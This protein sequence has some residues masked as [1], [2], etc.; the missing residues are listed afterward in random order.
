[1]PWE[2]LRKMVYGRYLLLK[3]GKNPELDEE[4]KRL[5]KKEYSL[6]IDYG[7]APK[8]QEEAEKRHSSAAST[9]KSRLD[10]AELEKFINN[11]EPSVIQ[12]ETMLLQNKDPKKAYNILNNIRCP[13]LPGFVDQVKLYLQTLDKIETQKKWI[14]LHTFETL[15]EL[16]Q[17]EKKKYKF[18]IF[19]ISN[20][21]D[22]Y[23]KAF[24]DLSVKDGSD[25]SSLALCEA[26]HH[27]RLQFLKEHNCST[28]NEYEQLLI[29]L[30]EQGRYDEKLFKSYLEARC[31]FGERKKVKR[32]YGKKAIETYFLDMRDICKK[33]FRH[34]FPK[35]SPKDF[36]VYYD[37]KVLLS[38]YEEQCLLSGQTLKPE[39]LSPSAISE[40][41][42]KTICQVMDTNKMFYRA[43]DAVKVD[44]EMKNISSVEVRLFEINTLT[45]YQKNTNQIDPT[46]DLDGLQPLLSFTKTYKLPSIQRHVESFDF[47]MIDHR[48]V[49]VIDFLAGMLNSRFLVKM[50]SLHALVRPSIAGYALTILDESGNQVVEKVKVMKGARVYLPTSHPATNDQEEQEE[51]QEIVIPF[52]N[53]GEGGLASVL[54]V[55]EVQP[56]WY[57]AIPQVIEIMEEHY[58]IHLAGDVDNESIVKGNEECQVILRPIASLNDR[59]FPISLLKD[60]TITIA[61]TASQDVRT[62]KTLRPTLKDGKEIVYSFRV[63]D[64]MVKLEATMT[65]SVPL[66][67]GKLKSLST[68]LVLY[69]HSE[70]TP[71]ENVKSVDIMTTL[72][73]RTNSL[74]TQ[75]YIA[76]L[77]GLSGEPIPDHSCEVIV[78]SLL[79]NEMHVQALVTDA[80]GQIHL[81]SLQDIVSLKVNGK[82]FC[83]YPDTFDIRE[84]WECSE[85][86]EI[87]AVFPLLSHSRWNIHL[88]CMSTVDAYP[89]RPLTNHLHRED[90]YLFVKGLPAG[91]YALRMCEPNVKEH[92]I[93]IYVHRSVIPMRVFNEF[94][95]YYNW[96]RYLQDLPLSLTTQITNDRKLLIQLRGGTDSRRVHLLVKHLFE[97]KMLGHSLQNGDLPSSDIHEIFKFASS[98][99]ANDRSL[100]DEY[101]YILNRKS[102]K[103]DLPGNMLP[104]PGPLLNPV[105]FADTVN[106]VQTA[107]EGR[108]FSD[109]RDGGERYMRCLPCRCCPHRMP[110]ITSLDCPPCQFPAC[111]AIIRPSELLVDIPLNKNGVGMID[112]SGASADGVEV[113]V[114]AVDNEKTVQRHVYVPEISPEKSVEKGASTLLCSQVLKNSLDCER[115]YIEEKIISLATEEQPLKLATKS[116]METIHSIADVYLLLKTL[117]ANQDLTNFSFLLSWDKLTEREKNEYY[118]RYNCSELNVFIYFRDRAF[119]DQVIL[120]YLRCK[121]E[122]SFLDL[123]LTG[124]DVTA[125]RKP[126][127]L[128][129]LNAFERALLCSQLSTEEAALLAQGVSG[130]EG[131]CM[132]VREFTRI[133][134]TVLKMKSMEDPVVAEA[135]EEEE[136]EEEEDSEEDSDLTM[137]EGEGEEI[138]RNMSI[139]ERERRLEEERRRNQERE[140]V[141]YSR[142]SVDTICHSISSLKAHMPILPPISPSM[143]G[144]QPRSSRFEYVFA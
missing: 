102:Q 81:G 57:F 43:G 93:R 113:V 103:R 117:T 119:F 126:Q 34:L 17:Y 87:Q 95:V 135:M 45:Y 15:H 125:F 3:Q 82:Q 130:S 78:Q 58:A 55:Q 48:G 11:A 86:E 71:R 23:M 127:L 60:V 31:V 20:F 88:Y 70:S 68:T 100:P 66:V 73:R 18:D 141:N 35:T 133:F 85:E 13:G 107:E 52:Q 114:V 28:E 33:Y 29:L 25:P 77:Y 129:R 79:T 90:G 92:I 94:A 9:D 30:S 120:P 16:Y 32:T 124:E 99:I 110:C 112:L 97:S 69:D 74:G 47:P 121:I 51:K 12:Y 138:K 91:S 109:C 98:Q 22:E 72:F 80:R 49:Y 142:A 56:N 46:I 143:A 44:V 137:S 108:K 19:S 5:L 54:L 65:A 42:K 36:L 84:T 50:G 140:C 116:D 39:Y 83:M 1:M 53:P 38:L 106:T 111:N 128:K 8:K 136:E 10:Y 4:L 59:V 118:N 144:I 132:N 89:F 21:R 62:E 40:L 64:Q 6:Q 2:Q 122:K 131:N 115:H 63:M 75:E 61:G 27:R 134:N 67:N 123:F 41:E 26:I 105:E 7:T 104:H 24:G 76:Q 14:N 101:A 139:R 96:A 37:P